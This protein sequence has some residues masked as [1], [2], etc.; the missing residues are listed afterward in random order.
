[1]ERQQKEYR[2]AKILSRNNRSFI[3]RRLIELFTYVWK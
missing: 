1:M 2:Q 3:E